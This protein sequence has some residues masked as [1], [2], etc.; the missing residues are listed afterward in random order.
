MSFAVSIPQQLLSTEVTAIE[1]DLKPGVKLSIR[2]HFIPEV[3]SWLETH[4]E[5]IPTICM[6]RFD[7]EPPDYYIIVPTQEIKTQFEIT[8]Y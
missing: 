2:F 3:K 6:K 7:F 8:W 4:L 5:T 1:G